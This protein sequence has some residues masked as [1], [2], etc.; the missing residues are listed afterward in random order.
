MKE[1]ILN[2]ITKQGILN[3]NFVK[4]N[5]TTV[6]ECYIIAYGKN[7]SCKFCKNETEFINWKKGFNEVC[8]DKIC[9]NKLANEKRKQTNLKKYDFI[10]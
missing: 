6:E 10:F 1:L 4:K 7:N 5:N 2:N 9:R 3:P 8:V